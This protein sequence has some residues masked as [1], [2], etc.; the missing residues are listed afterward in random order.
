MSTKENI[1]VNENI[2]VNESINTTKFN[3]DYNNFD[4]RTNYYYIFSNFTAFNNSKRLSKYL[5]IFFS[6]AFQI[7]RSYLLI[8]K[9]PLERRTLKHLFNFICIMNRKIIDKL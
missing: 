2:S 6:Y 4:E 7:F 5:I 1:K 9:W 8:Y 3:K